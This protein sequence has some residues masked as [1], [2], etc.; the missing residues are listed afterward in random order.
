MYNGLSYNNFLNRYSSSLSSRIKHQ[1]TTCCCTSCNN[2]NQEGRHSPL[3]PMFLQLQDNTADYT[4]TSQPWNDTSFQAFKSIAILHVCWTT[5]LFKRLLTILD[6][7]VNEQNE[8]EEVLNN[9][10]IIGSEKCGGDKRIKIIFH[11]C[12]VKQVIISQNTDCEPC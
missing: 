12:F 3:I 7:R 6:N 11:K 2:H 9:I 8:D 1:S 4:L 5:K 10:N